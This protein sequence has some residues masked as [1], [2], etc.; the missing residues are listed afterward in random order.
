M[1]TWFICHRAFPVQEV[2]EIFGPDRCPWK[3]C[4]FSKN[5]NLVKKNHSFIGPENTDAECNHSRLPFTVSQRNRELAW[6]W[7]GKA[8]KHLASCRWAEESPGQAT[9][10]LQ[11]HTWACK[12]LLTPPCAREGPRLVSPSRW[13]SVLTRSLC[14]EAQKNPKEVA[15]GVR[16]S[17][18]ISTE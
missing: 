12:A 10:L 17:L 7:E 8:P 3:K 2:C 11:G 4:S 15:E 16:N 5:P 9:S 1:F 18:L 13:G 6:G 14:S